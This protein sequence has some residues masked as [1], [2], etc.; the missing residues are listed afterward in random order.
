MVRQR[1]PAEGA[2]VIGIEGLIGA[3]KSTAVAAL[4]E[5]FE[6]RPFYEPV[7]TN[8]YLSRFYEDPDRWA[9]A[10]QAHLLTHRYA[11]HQTAGWGAFAGYASVID[12]TMAG[13]RVFC[14]VQHDAGRLSTA[15][16]RTYEKLHAL[17]AGSIQ[18]PTTLVFLDVPPKVALER[19]RE[20][21]RAAESGLDLDY[22]KRLYDG[23]LR[24]LDDILDQKHAWSRSLTVL[25]VPYDHMTTGQLVTV[26]GESLGLCRVEE[27][28]ADA[29]T[30]RS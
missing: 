29:P 23:Y 10:M 22:L 2:H 5:A 25:E 16:W 7:A 21:G 26:V 11:T 13:D 8:P 24:L 9:F 15:E 28:Q 1:A 18:V 6:L 30:L 20:R 17:M 12:R 14:K 27:S 19:A 3:G 4:A